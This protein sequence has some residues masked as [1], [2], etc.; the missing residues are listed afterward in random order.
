MHLLMPPGLLWY[1]DTSQSMASLI[2]VTET[3]FICNLIPSHGL[4]WYQVLKFVWLS[5]IPTV[6]SLARL[7]CQAGTIRP[8]NPD[9]KK[10]WKHPKLFSPQ[11]IKYWL[12][13]HQRYG[14]TLVVKLLFTVNPGVA[15]RHLSLMSVY[16]WNCDTLA[17][18]MIP[19]N[20]FTTAD[21]FNT[22]VSH[23]SDSRT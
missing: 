19:L 5:E 8:V 11:A 12:Q 14:A 7:V 18:A 10:G 13:Y 9:K 15:F 4:N 20:H 21:W 16:H 6:W 2:S 3:K 22:D 23:R 17:G 1:G